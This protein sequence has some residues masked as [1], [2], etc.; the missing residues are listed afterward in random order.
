MLSIRTDFC[1]CNYTKE[2]AFPLDLWNSA[3]LSRGSGFFFSLNLGIMDA[4]V[5]AKTAI[6][7]ASASS[8]SVNKS[9]PRATTTAVGNEP[10]GKPRPERRFW[11]QKR[12][13]YDPQ[14]VGTQPSV[15]DDPA[16]A[17]QYQPRQ[18]WENLHRFNPSARWTWEEEDAVVRKT[19]WRIM[20]WA[21]I[22]F[23]GL[24][25]DR[26]NLSQALTDNFLD[27]LGM[28]TNDYNMGNTVFSLS[29]L[30]AELPSQL[31]SKWVGPDRWIPAQLV[32]WSLVAICQFK[33]NGYTSFIICR[34]LLGLLQGGFIPDPS[35]EWLLLG[36]ITLK[37][38]NRC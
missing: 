2:K 14:A 36:K 22:M 37:I 4:I 35:L 9:V 24:E 32:L 18:D 1:A 13:N 6:D 23:V 10:L 15:Y 29:F 11:F 28:T 20:I 31:V 16:L 5:P 19:D 34:C 17:P 12:Q 7:S 33:L 38:M 30:C 21:C 3:G 26:A 25:I 27:D 8:E